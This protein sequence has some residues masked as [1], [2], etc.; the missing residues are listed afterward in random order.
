MAAPIEHPVK[1]LTEFAKH[2]EDALD[3]SRG[4][5]GAKPSIVNWYRGSGE[6]TTGKLVPKLYRHPTMKTANELLVLE[7]QMLNWFKRQSILHQ[8]L[9]PNIDPDYEYLFFMQHYGVPTRLLDW[10]GN[11]FIALYFALT[12]APYDATHNRY[13]ED[14]AVWILSPNAWNERSLLD[15]SWGP[16]GP[17][18]I[19]DSEKSGYA[20][21]TSDDPNDL[22]AMYEL[23]IAMHGIPNNTRMFAQKGVFTIFGKVTDP[24]EKIFSDSAYPVESLVKLTVDKGDIPNFLDRVLSVGFTDSVSYPDLHGLALEIKRHFGFRM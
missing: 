13:N 24:M 1:T 16:K 21:R 15:I 18:G 11:P 19:E 8:T 22:K 10:T 23:P 6:S 3:L 7:R 2:V 14:A 12:S 9:T 4:K 17:V 20:P 5:Y